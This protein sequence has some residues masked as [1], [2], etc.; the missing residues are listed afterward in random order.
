[1]QLGQLLGLQQVRS[2]LLLLLP[3]L[4][5]FV[6]VVRCGSS[7]VETFFQNTIGCAVGYVALLYP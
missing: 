1:V 3:L 4:M 7:V 6:F 5:L 2:P